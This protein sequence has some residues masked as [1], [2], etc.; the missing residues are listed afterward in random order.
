L[1][2]NTLLSNLSS[3]TLSLH[4]S[5]NVNDQVSHPYRTGK[6]IVL[7]VFNLHIFG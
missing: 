6:I 3:I 5:S 4:S 7:Y 1:G 2:P